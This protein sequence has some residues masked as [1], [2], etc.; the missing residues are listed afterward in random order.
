MF[1]SYYVAF[2]KEDNRYWL[3]VPDLP[4]CFSCGEDFI[5]TK[6]MGKEA[7]ELYLDG[8]DVELIPAKS[9]IEDI[10]ATQGE[11]VLID[12]EMEVRDGKL[13]TIK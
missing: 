3:E 6:I 12:V 10:D 11:L 4:G 9:T 7:I 2:H 8:I 1:L 13:C 5:T